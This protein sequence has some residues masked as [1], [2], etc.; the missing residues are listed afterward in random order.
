MDRSHL[1]RIFFLFVIA[2]LIVIVVPV[3]VFAGDEQNPEITD[4]END[5][6]THPYFYGPARSLKA[7]DIVS[8]WFHEDQ[9]ESDYLFIT[10][11]VVDLNHL[12][13]RSTYMVEW[14]HEVYVYT[15]SLSTQF[16]GL[17][18]VAVL[19]RS[20]PVRIHFVKTIFDKEDNLVTFIIPKNFIDNPL[21]GD[22]LTRTRA[23]STI[24]VAFGNYLDFYFAFDM[25]PDFQPSGKNYI[26]QY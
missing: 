6:Y 14:G 9:N 24:S 22:V 17:F 3:S 16:F 19:L 23:A 12:W 26:V 7:I 21:P 10:I 11:K 1:K 4:D 20:Y 8:A 5:M 18:S 2:Q 25:A 13:L 15:A